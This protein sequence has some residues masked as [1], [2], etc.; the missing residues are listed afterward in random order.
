MTEIDSGSQMIVCRRCGR[1]FV[2]TGSYLAL[3]KR[4]NARVI[5]PVVC[6][7]CFLRG[8]PQPK[9][10]G[11]VKWFDP[12]KRY[13]FIVTEEGEDVFLHQSQMLDDHGPSPQPGQLVRFH[14]HY[15]VKGPEA[16]NVELIE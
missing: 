12:H 8:G 1:G 9:E 13:G 11:E 7:T 2:L 4:R 6:P 5:A 15:A 14:L 10:Q 3:L 16:H